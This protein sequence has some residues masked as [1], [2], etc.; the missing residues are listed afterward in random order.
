MLIGDDW[1]CGGLIGGWWVRT[2]ERTNERKDDCK[3]YSS[4]TIITI[5]RNTIRSII[6]QYKVSIP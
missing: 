5:S 4:V 2:N 6:I 3:C 1:V